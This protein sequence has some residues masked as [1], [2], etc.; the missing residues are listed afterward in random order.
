MYCTNYYYHGIYENGYNNIYLNTV[1]PECSICLELQKSQYNC[2]VEIPVQLQTTLYVKMCDCNI[3]IHVSCLDQWYNLNYNCPICRKRMYKIYR[4]LSLLRCIIMCNTNILFGFIHAI[5][6]ILK[7]VR[8]ILVILFWYN[9]IFMTVF[10]V[11][12]PFIQ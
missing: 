6:H 11:R 9:V 10:I 7:L 3:W 4:C 2:I 1:I 8:F 5:I 12:L